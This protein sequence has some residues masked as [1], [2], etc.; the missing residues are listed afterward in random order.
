MIP[1]LAMK[2]SARNYRVIGV[3]DSRLSRFFMSIKSVHEQPQPALKARFYRWYRPPQHS[4]LP[5]LHLTVHLLL[6]SDWSEIINRWLII[7]KSLLV[8][9][10]KSAIPPPQPNLDPPSPQTPSIWPNLG[11]P[12]PTVCPNLCSP[13]PQHLPKSRCPLPKYWSKCGTPVP[14]PTFGQICAPPSTTNYI[15]IYMYCKCMCIM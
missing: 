12:S 5:R 13:L 10:S 2:L 8:T 9:L 7:W 15:W 1:A 3:N 4:I 6:F 11:A 14:F